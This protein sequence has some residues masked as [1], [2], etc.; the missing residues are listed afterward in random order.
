MLSNV[1][2]VFYIVA[3]LHRRHEAADDG[4]LALPAPPP[5]LGTL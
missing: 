1:D 2:V 3:R 5:L 4:A